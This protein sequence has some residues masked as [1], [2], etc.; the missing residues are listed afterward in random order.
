MTSLFTRRTSS[1][2]RYITVFQLCALADV[3]RG[4][5]ISNNIPR[6][7]PPEI[8]KPLLAEEDGQNEGAK[9]LTI[10]NIINNLVLSVSNREES[11]LTA[12]AWVLTLSREDLEDRGYEEL[13]DLL[14]D[15]PGMDVVR[16]YGDTYYRSYWR[17]A[18]SLIGAPYLLL[19]DGLMFNHLYTNEAEI[20]AALP[21]SAVLRVEIVYGPASAVYG[22]NAEM[23]VIN[24]IT[25]AQ[26]KGKEGLQSAGR[27]L[28][29][30]PTGSQINFH[31]M[32]KVADGWVRWQSGR[33]WFSAAARFDSIVL[34]P[35]VAGRFEYTG[36]RYYEDPRFYGQFLLLDELAGPFR[37]ENRKE[38]ID[39]RLGYGNAELGFQRYRMRSGGGIVYAA[40][41]VPNRIPYITLEQSL[42]LRHRQV[43]GDVFS[44]TMMIRFRESHVD[45]PTA[46]LEFDHDTQSVNFQYW[47]STNYAFTA[48]MD[49]S[50]LAFRGLLTQRDEL[51]I[52][53]G[54]RYER[55]DLERDYITS[56]EDSWDP[57]LP[58]NSAVADLPSYVFPQPLGAERQLANRDSVDTFG[59][60]ALGRYQ[61]VNGHY[62]NLGVRVD[63]NSFFGDITPIFRGGYVG[64]VLPQL[65]V[66][67]LYGQALREPNRGVL[68][69]GDSIAASSTRLPR[70]RSQTGELSVAYQL[71]SLGLQA[72]VW[73][74]DIGQ[75][76][77]SRQ[78]RPRRRS[79]SSPRVTQRLMIGTDLSA[80]GLIGLSSS[81]HIK[82]WAYYSLYLLAEEEVV[83]ADGSLSRR[84][85]PDLAQHKVLGGVT[86]KL[87]RF[88]SSTVLGRCISDRATVVTNP[89]PN[90]GGYCELDANVSI[91]DLLIP[92]V[93]CSIG[94][95]NLLDTPFSHP[96]IGAADSGETPGVWTAD[97]RW[98]GSQGYFNSLL[99]QPGRALSV[100]I[101]LDF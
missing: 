83:M 15:L 63:H 80:V 79:E 55:R 42:Y 66:K 9:I 50:L 45:S 85:I 40:D 90:V 36:N 53:F 14:D 57:R 25:R 12:P 60:Y 97:G 10:E 27:F 21:I 18:R 98:I 30:T 59:L 7:L 38:A 84:R 52:D 26:A 95:D 88:F 61:I 76:S 96:G 99:P 41:R 71:E 48:T 29:R 46:W 92:G 89:I 77:N 5:D 65:T 82:L 4:Q 6:D 13:T 47:Q 28:L 69:G 39:V 20:M 91:R 8:T 34:D 75:V 78:G 64:Q 67:L 1:I 33:I 2:L 72:N 35:S 11:A 68:F 17:G 56:G 44:S 31:N 62:L 100:H 32:S 24:V 94:A 19:V 70:E 23:G 3:A 43:H 73:L 22:P 101:G 54:G 16:P 74:V 86:A 51:V 81:H 87:H 37:S 93:W 49:F 58:F